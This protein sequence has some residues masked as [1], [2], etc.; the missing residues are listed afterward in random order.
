LSAEFDG[1]LRVLTVDD[2]VPAGSLIG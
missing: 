2:D 1:K